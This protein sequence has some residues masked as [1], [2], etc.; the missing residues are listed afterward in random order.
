MI[1]AIFESFRQ[2]EI[3][4]VKIQNVNMVIP[5]H[6]KQNTISGLT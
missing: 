1:A 2:H 3:Y 5:S 6:G 4:L